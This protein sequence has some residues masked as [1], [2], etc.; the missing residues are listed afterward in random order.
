MRAR[1]RRVAPR[2]KPQAA[3]AVKVQE[4]PKIA[5][6]FQFANQALHAARAGW[7]R[8]H[9][10]SK[11]SP[12]QA[13]QQRRRL[14]PPE[15]EIQIRVFSILRHLEKSLSRPGSLIS[16]RIRHR[17]QIPRRAAAQVAV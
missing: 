16:V 6:A 15:R 3:E 4:E 1:G 11:L 13:A 8:A 9:P 14:A 17:Q 5:E 7:A 12:E 2:M 10:P